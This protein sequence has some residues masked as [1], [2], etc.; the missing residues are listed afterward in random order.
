MICVMF[1]NP[2]MKG[3]IMR[4]KV[5]FSTSNLHSSFLGNK[6]FLSFV[7]NVRQGTLWL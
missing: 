4:L 6:N 1:L 2:S 7:R 3:S 5:M